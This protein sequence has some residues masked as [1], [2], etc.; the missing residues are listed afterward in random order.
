[1]HSIFEQIRSWAHQRN[2]IDGATQHAQMLKLTE[3]VGELAAAI[4]KNKRGNM[5]EE[6]GDCVVVLTIL[7]E[8][9]GMNIEDCIVTAYNKIRHRKGKMING[10]F[11]K[12]ED[13][14][15]KK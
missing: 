14:A 4:A 6:I 12:E 2:L 5:E 13:Y 3:E 10:T 15:K 8:Q 9:A 7:A 11:I 1:M